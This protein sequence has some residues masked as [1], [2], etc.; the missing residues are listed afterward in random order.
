[1]EV[2]FA[3]AAL[4]CKGEPCLALFVRL[5][6]VWYSLTRLGEKVQNQFCKRE[7]GNLASYGGGRN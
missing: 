6:F 4:G 5:C 2:S 1:M 3:N 7:Y